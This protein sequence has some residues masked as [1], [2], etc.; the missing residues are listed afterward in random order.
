MRG[1][2]ELLEPQCDVR[3]DHD[4]SVMGPAL[5]M[6][7]NMQRHH[8]FNSLFTFD[9]GISPHDP[10]SGPTNE[11]CARG[12]AGRAGQVVGGMDESGTVGGAVGALRHT[13][14]SR[15]STKRNL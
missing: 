14:T 1:V 13:F 4:S 3:L 6:P 2:G 7:F 10:G 5:P 8:A 12:G 15:S 9:E 11:W